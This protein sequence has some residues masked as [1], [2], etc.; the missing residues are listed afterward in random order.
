MSWHNFNAT[1][2]VFCSYYLKFSS[3]ELNLMK[4]SKD[5][6]PVEVHSFCVDPKQLRLKPAGE[7]ELL[8]YVTL[9]LPL[10]FLGCSDEFKSSFKSGLLF[11]SVSNIDF[12]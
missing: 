7:G 2:S 8:L 11:F 10:K 4:F 6:L 12:R 1:A 9:R 5:R 3:N